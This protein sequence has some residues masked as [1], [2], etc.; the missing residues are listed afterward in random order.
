MIFAVDAGSKT[1]DKGRAAAERLVN[2]M[3]QDDLGRTDASN[4]GV[5]SV[6]FG[7]VRVGSVRGVW[8]VVFVGVCWL[9][10][11]LLCRG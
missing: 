6:R 10:F 3:V 8:E 1:S 4:E 5:W 9:V 11:L 2:E 7:S